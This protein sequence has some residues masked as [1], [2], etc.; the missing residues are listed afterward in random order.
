MRPVARVAVSPKRAGVFAYLGCIRYQEVLVL[1]GSPLLGAVFAH[2]A[3]TV[4]SVVTAGLM[5]A[6]SVL[7]VAHIWTFNDWAGAAGDANDP[8]R[9]GAVFATRGVSRRGVA[10][11]SLVLLGASL[12]LLLLLPRP[13]LLLGLVIALLGGL[14]SHPLFNAKGTAVISSLP[15]LIGGALHFL[16]GYSVFAPL[17]RQGTLLALFFAL[18]F[19]AGHLNQEVRDHDGDRLNGIR[20]NAVV[21]GKGV[22]FAAGFVLFTLAYA[23][24]GW[25]AWAGVVP[26]KIGV[27]A[28]VLYPIHVVWS[29]T[30][31]RAGLSFESVSRFRTRYRLLYAVIGLAMLAAL[32]LA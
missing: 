28:V 10:A 9:S 14:Y 30:T 11:L 7:L 31:L 20:T 27:L 26:A 16:L 23:D 25:L 2:P 12:A 19:T 3:L 8:N 18:T 32:L 6:A 1:Q 4:E 22:A 29:I 17:D 15:H 13:T 24:L 21:F 5:A